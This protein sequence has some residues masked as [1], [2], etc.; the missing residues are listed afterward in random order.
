M[1]RGN[2]I[3]ILR[4]LCGAGF[5]VSDDEA[6]KAMVLAYEH[7]RIVVE[8]GGAVALAAALFYGDE[9]N[10][11]DVIVVATGGNVDTSIFQNALIK[12]AK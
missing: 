6:I 3:P 5:S 12:Y 10:N 9:L 4:K 8:P 11:E 7:L 1:P 2:H